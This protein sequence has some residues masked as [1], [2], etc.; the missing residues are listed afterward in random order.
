MAVV[1]GVVMCL[2]SGCGTPGAQPT[3]TTSSTQ[4]ARSKPVAV[5]RADIVSVITVNGTVT[6]TPEYAVTA[7]QDGVVVQANGW[8]EGD[9]VRPGSVLGW[10]PG[11]RI[12]A[13]MEGTFVRWLVPNGMK[14]SAGV[15]VAVLRYGG[16]GI[17]AQVPAAQMFR[18]Y[19]GVKDA[20]AQMTG[21]PG[22]SRCAIVMHP[23]LAR[24]TRPSGDTSGEPTK[25]PYPVLCLLGRSV[26]VVPGLSAVVGL[27]SGERDNVLVL[28]VTAVAGEAQKGTVARMVD[29]APVTTPVT[30]GY[31]DGVQVEIRSGLAEGD[32]VLPYG[33][34]LRT[35]VR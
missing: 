12:R 33:P 31:S 3:T 13:T 7:H 17:D 28:P 6:A 35:V 21:G 5:R 26:R 23:S 10:Q 18:L 14:V 2:I 32:E 27:N 8:S 11:Q 4:D 16:F 20:R 25:V 29:G 19:R 22:P 24:S 1:T 30:L 15:P 34:G 9:R